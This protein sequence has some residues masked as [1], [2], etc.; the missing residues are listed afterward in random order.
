ME[1]I[2]KLEQ[3][4][5]ESEFFPPPGISYKLRQ[6]FS[7]LGIRF[8]IMLMKAGPYVRLMDLCKYRYVYLF[9]LTGSHFSCVSAEGEADKVFISLHVQPIEQLSMK[10][11]CSSL[12]TTQ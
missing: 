10:F 1:T 4:P 7:H 8:A 11:F 2:D 9:V 5:A 3:A 6:I 12:L